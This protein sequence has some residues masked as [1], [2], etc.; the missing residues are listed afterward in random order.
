MKVIR[1]MGGL[2]FMIGLLIIVFIG[3]PWYVYQDP[4]L[5]WWMKTAVY[6]VMGGILVVL[7][8]VGVEYRGAVPLKQTERPAETEKKILLFNTWE[9]PDRKVKESLGLVKGHTIFAVSLGKD[10]SALMRLIPG[11]ELTEYTEMMRE[12]R[13][14]AILR[15]KAEAEAIDADAV[16][17]VRY[18][19]A[20]VVTGAAE[21]L[22]YGTAVKLE[23]RGD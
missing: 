12:A 23:E 17:N 22:A 3:I 14:L 15:M 7:A 1:W 19:T 16:L 13:E 9:I 18:V 2:A 4:M 10:L 6:L 11:G 21:L 20:S 5:P 8:A